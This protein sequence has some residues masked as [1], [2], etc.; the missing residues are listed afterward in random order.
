M[1]GKRLKEIRK[2]KGFRVR[3]TRIRAFQKCDF[4]NKFTSRFTSRNNKKDP[5]HGRGQNVILAK[6]TC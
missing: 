3:V 6:L 5:A 1:I 2:Q 4:L